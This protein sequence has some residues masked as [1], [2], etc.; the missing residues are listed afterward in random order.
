MVETRDRSF[1]RLAGTGISEFFLPNFLIPLPN[2]RTPFPTRVGLKLYT[3]PTGYLFGMVLAKLSCLSKTLRRSYVSQV[4]GQYLVSIYD[5]MRM[6]QPFLLPLWLKLLTQTISKWSKK[7]LNSLYSIHLHAMSSQM[8][9]LAP[10]II[11]MGQVNLLSGN[12]IKVRI[13]VSN[14]LVTL[15][16]SSSPT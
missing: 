12:S 3:F 2:R 9:Y 6:S 8:R 14:N 4:A 7:F 11:I 13:N 15:F 1:L 5:G 10:R 16:R